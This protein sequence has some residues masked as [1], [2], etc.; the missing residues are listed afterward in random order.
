MIDPT[1]IYIVGVGL[2]PVGE[3]WQTSLRSI[4]LEAIH[5]AMADAPGLRPDALYVANMLAPSLSGQAH[6]G[7]LLSDFA[8]LRG[9]EAVTVEAAGASGGLALRQAVLAVAAGA[10]DVALV[11]GAEKITDQVGPG[12]DSALMASG[13]SDYEA[14]HGL[15]PTALAALRMRRYLHEFGAPPDALAGFSL[16]AHAHALDNPNAFFRKAIT[17][18][19]YRRAPMVSEPVNLY[20]AAPV[21]DG[22]AAL[23]LV[24]GSALHGESPAPVRVLGIGVATSPV[25]LHEIRDPLDLPAS[26]LSAEKAYAS[27]RLA[28]TDV[29]FFE[30]HDSFTIYAAMAVEAAG[31]AARG[32]GWRLAREGKIGLEGPLPMLTFGGSKARGDTGGATGVYQLAEAT[33]QVQHRANGNQVPRAGVGMVQCLGGTGGTAVTTLL[34]EA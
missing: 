2:T 24:R 5:K 25:A 33:L 31:F 4:A 10:H 17:E 34:G 7:S 29:D 12:L 3:H 11:V 20:D 1:S 14:A 21:A 27:A 13:D 9:I 6:L 30:P 18:D 15:T 32:Q 16:A 28:A 8:G 22:A 26:R 23:L 19:D